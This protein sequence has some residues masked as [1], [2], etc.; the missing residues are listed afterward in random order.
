MIGGGGAE[1]GGRGGGGGTLSP[2]QCRVCARDDAE[3][4]VKDVA[5][6]TRTSAGR[7]P[8]L[9]GCPG[10]RVPSHQFPIG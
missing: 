9:R 10:R 8:E 6:V 5:T 7:R 1:W 2:V 3:V 4:E